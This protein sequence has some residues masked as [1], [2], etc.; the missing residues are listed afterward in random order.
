LK[1]Q[2]NCKLEGGTGTASLHKQATPRGWQVTTPDYHTSVGRPTRR[3][4]AVATLP[5][6]GTPFFPPYLS[7]FF[8][9]FPHFWALWSTPPHWLQHMPALLRLL[10]K[11]SNTHN[12]LSVGPIIIKFVLT[13]SLLRDASS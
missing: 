3:R 8:S 10:L 5:Y 2:K 1:L 6:T 11:T 12:L 13:R 4:L 9:S 7:L